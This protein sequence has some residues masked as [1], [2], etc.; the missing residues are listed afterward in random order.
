MWSWGNEPVPDLR[1]RG[2]FLKVI[3]I[4]RYVLIIMIQMEKKN[5]SSPNLIETLQVYIFL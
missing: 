3:Y 4:K 2:R 1:V 5:S